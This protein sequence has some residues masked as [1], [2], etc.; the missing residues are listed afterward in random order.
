MCD[1]ATLP[2]RGMSMTKRMLS[3]VAVVAC[4]SVASSGLGRAQTF[5]VE[6][7]DI[8]GDGGTDYVAVEAATGR[9]FVSRGTH[10]MVVDGATGK[11]RRRHPEHAG[12]ARRRHR[13]QSRSR[14]HDQRRRLDR[15]DVRSE[16]ARRDQADQGGA[17][18]SRRHHVRRARRQDHPDESQPPDRHAH[19]DRSEDRRHRRRPSNSRTTRPKAPPPTARG[20]SSSTTR[21]RTRSR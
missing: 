17:G 20:T 21:A 13:H 9:V 2:N 19:R 1:G 11:V 16:D 18:R 3:L 7:F 8:K 12:C 14:L 5:K 6:K 15:H 10:M 4:L